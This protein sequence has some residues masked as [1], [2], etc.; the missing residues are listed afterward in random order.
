MSNQQKKMQKKKD[1]EREV[2]KKIL[3]RRARIREEARQEYLKNKEEME[4]QAVVNRHTVT[5]CHNDGQRLSEDEIK[6]RL[7][8]NME[9]LQALQAEQEEFERQRREALK[10]PPDFGQ[11]AVR[12]EEFKRMIGGE[13]ECSFKP[14]S[15]DESAPDQPTPTEEQP[16]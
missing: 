7:K 11:L 3:R 10:N 2:R 1:R 5:V 9:I 12:P 4:N 16:Q 6:E 15:E 13:A 14:N 8:K